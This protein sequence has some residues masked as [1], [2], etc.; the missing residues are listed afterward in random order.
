MCHRA[1][2]DPWTRYADLEV[3]AATS[4]VTAVRSDCLGHGVRGTVTC[5][6]GQQERGSIAD[7]G[8][9]PNRI[10][11]WAA[12]S[13]VL[14][15]GC[16]GVPY[17]P[18]PTFEPSPSRPSA[19]LTAPPGSEASITAGSVIELHGSI[20]ADDGQA[21]QVAARLELGDLSSPR[22][23][24]SENRSTRRLKVYGTA[25]LTNP[26]DRINVPA[27]AVDL[28]FQ[29]GY[30][31]TSPACQALPAPEGLTWGTYCWYLLG[32]TSAV[33]SRGSI[34]ALQPGEQRT[35]TVTTRADGRGQ[36]RTSDGAARRTAAALR[37]PAVVVVL[38][39]A[40][41][42]EGTRLRGGCESLSTVV[43]PSGPATPPTQPREDLLTDHAVAAAS[44]TLTC[45][46][47][48]YI[49]P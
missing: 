5:S 45:G 18:G 2:S 30:P 35:R 3:G 39:S 34:T 32:T 16:S 19:S 7:T 43:T 15:A 46:D 27:A 25:T 47:L 33:D 1:M 17:A 20:A 37:R 13:A 12:V 40:V 14:T 42:Y 41:G 6:D 48:R 8:A 11:C 24:G 49:G 9:V 29:A 21:A 22:R 38:T 23:D 4:R 28:V 44:T 26:T 31:R 10:H 36:I